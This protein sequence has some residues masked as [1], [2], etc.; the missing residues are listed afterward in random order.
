MK[1]KRFFS[2]SQQKE[3]ED[4][5]EVLENKVRAFKGEVLNSDIPVDVGVHISADGRIW[6]CING[7]AFVKSFG[8]V[9]TIKDDK[10]T[11]IWDFITN[12]STFQPVIDSLSA[13]V[14][15]KPVK[16]VFITK[17]RKEKQNGL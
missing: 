3:L 12:D 7:A 4:K 9:V 17:E 15:S 5:I 10:I 13:Y 14:K 6:V 1:E 8:D 11:S 16:D 2:E